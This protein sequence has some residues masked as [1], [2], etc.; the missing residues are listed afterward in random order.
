MVYDIPEELVTESSMD[1]LSV[2]LPMGYAE[3]KWACKKFLESAAMQHA[4]EFEA[5]VLRIGAKSQDRGYLV[6]GT[7]TIFP[8]L[9]SVS[10]NWVFLLFA[11]SR[12]RNYHLVHAQLSLQTLIS[13]Q[14]LSWLP[15]DNATRAISKILTGLGA[16]HVVP[17]RK[18]RETAM[19]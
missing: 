11:G 1:D 19:A 12:G 4:T 7:R 8:H 9:L 10:V 13:L 18:S 5:V 3:G 14:T 16:R 17:C 2:A 15:V 6:L